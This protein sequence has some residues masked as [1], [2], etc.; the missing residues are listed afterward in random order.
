MCDNCKKAVRS[1]RL[2]Q[3]TSDTDKFK[4]LLESIEE[5]KEDMKRSNQTLRK[6]IEVQAGE[7][8]EIKEQLQK[9]SDHIDENTA[10][11]VNL[12]KTV[13][14]LVKKIDDMNDVQK[15]VDKQIVVLSDRINEIQQQSLGN[16]V[17]ISGYP[18]LPDE[19][20]MQMIIKLGDV[21]GYPISEHMISDCYRIRQHRSDTRPGLL[22]VAFVRKIDKKGFYSAAWSKK[23]LN[24]RDVGIILGE[25]ARIYV[26]NSL[27][28]Q[29]R[30]LLHACKEYKRTNS[31]KFMWVRDGRMFLKKDENSP[32]VNITSQEVLLRLASSA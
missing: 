7:L 11:L 31:Y 5:I 24:I 29:N 6:D 32:R 27:T 26:N 18:Q 15:R 19:N 17:E 1:S 20:I 12:D 23:D 13:D 9:Y 10:K 3:A 28:P 8:S 21:V 30:K 25:P 14:T 16:V 2:D 22:I 4:V